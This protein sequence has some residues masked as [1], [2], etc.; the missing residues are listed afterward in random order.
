MSVLSIYRLFRNR[1]MDTVVAVLLL[2]LLAHQVGAAERGYAERFREIA[3]PHQPVQKYH[4]TI[5]RYLTLVGDLQ[6]TR[7]LEA[8]VK[9][10]YAEKLHFSDTFMIAQHREQVVKHFLGLRDADAEIDL[11]VHDV[12]HSD[13]G[14]YLVWSADNSFSILGETTTAPS[15]GVTLFKLDEHG[16]IFLQQDFWDSTHGFYQ[17]LPILGGALRTIRD[18]IAEG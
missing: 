6:G 13:V 15:I 16:R 9:V 10:L 12:L 17:H 8:E 7:D 14:I 3:A 18:R 1:A 11:H 5:H 4:P 2:I